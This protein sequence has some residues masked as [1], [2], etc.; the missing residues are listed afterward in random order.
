VG[1]QI[2]MTTKKPVGWKGQPIRH[3]KAYYKG[4]RKAT[5]LGAN[6]Y[7]NGRC[8]HCKKIGHIY[9]AHGIPLKHSPDG[10]IALCKKCWGKKPKT[11]SACGCGV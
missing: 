6:D 3:K 2:K 1:F 9:I 7:P 4:R 11:Y 8:A 5:Y 10:H